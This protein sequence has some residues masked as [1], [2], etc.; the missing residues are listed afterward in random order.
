MVYGHLY[1]HRCWLVT[2]RRCSD[3]CS[4]PAGGGNAS[5][6]VAQ[7]FI[8]FIFQIQGSIDHI[9]RVTITASLVTKDLPHRPHP[10]CLVGKDCPD[11]SGICVV[12]FNPHNS[13]RHRFACVSCSFLS[14]A[15]ELSCVCVWP[16]IHFCRFRSAH[17]VLLT[18][19]SSVWGGKSWTFPFRSEETKTST[20]FRVSW[21]PT[22]TSSD[23][24]TYK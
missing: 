21:I 2:C 1:R 24:Y 18:L 17:A 4:T 5:H 20:P 15:D 19:A 11:G 7:A 16:Q 22:S 10:H 6:C 23:L 9:K 3:V 13:R 12:S 14:T 8:F